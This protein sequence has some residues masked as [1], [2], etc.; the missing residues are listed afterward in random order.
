MVQ[1]VSS[2]S[3]ALKLQ[4]VVQTVSPVGAFPDFYSA[5]LDD[6]TEAAPDC[7][8]ASALSAKKQLGLPMPHIPDSSEGHHCWEVGLRPGDKGTKVEDPSKIKARTW[9]K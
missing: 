1:F 7:C 3:P 5:P 8:P 4:M 2:H 9:I 6:H